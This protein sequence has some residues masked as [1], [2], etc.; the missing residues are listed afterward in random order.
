MYEDDVDQVWTAAA[1]AS[2][3][4]ASRTIH[5]AVKHA[6]AGHHSAGVSGGAREVEMFALSLGL[7][8][9]N[10][11]IPCLALNT[12]SARRKYRT[13]CRAARAGRVLLN[14]V[15]FQL[16]RP[17]KFLISKRFRLKQIL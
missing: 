4:S 6:A 9:F 13:L 17:A 15:F 11:E 5:P 2:Q 7:R 12:T 3:K 10:V 14:D 1:A 16:G 8:N